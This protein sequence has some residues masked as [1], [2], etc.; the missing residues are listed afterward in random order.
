MFYLWMI[1]L[2]SDRCIDAVGKRPEGRAPDHHTAHP[3]DARFYGVALDV[4]ALIFYWQLFGSFILAT[5]GSAI[6]VDNLAAV[7]P[8]GLRP[9]AA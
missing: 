7:I 4:R 8:V 9:A 1:D 6:G 5:V 2:G 3:I